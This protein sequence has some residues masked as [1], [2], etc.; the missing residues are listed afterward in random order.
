[1]PLTPGFLQASLSS[2][3]RLATDDWERRY[4]DTSGDETFRLN[5]Q[6]NHGRRSTSAANEFTRRISE[7]FTRISDRYKNWKLERKKADLNKSGDKAYDKILAGLS[8]AAGSSRKVHQGLK[9]LHNAERKLFDSHARFGKNLDDMPTDF[10]YGRLGEVV[11]HILFHK[12][13]NAQK[14][15]REFTIGSSKIIEQYSDLNKPFHR[16][17]VRLDKFGLLSSDY[18]TLRKQRIDEMDNKIKDSFEYIE[19]EYLELKALIDENIERLKCRQNGVD[20]N[21]DEFDYDEFDHGHV[22]DFDDEFASRRR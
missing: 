12:D 7:F 2:P 17:L 11:A 8:E 16:M 9:R 15:L 19:R 5:V 21:S 22:L 18:V 4:P 14:N 1:M 6:A 3:S 20:F 13:L 10:V